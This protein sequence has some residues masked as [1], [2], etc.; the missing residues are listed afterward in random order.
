MEKE[1][2]KSKNP[3]D[4]RS[5]LTGA[6][7]AAGVAGLAASTPPVLL[8][9]NAAL[10]PEAH[11]AVDVTS[12]AKPGSDFMVDVFKTLGIEYIAANPGSSFRG[13]QE[14]S[15]NY[16][17]NKSPEWLTCC[18]EESSVAMAHGYAKIEGK[19]M[20][21]M[22]H[23]TVGLQH[24]SMAIYNA[25]CDRAP[26]YIVLGNILDVNY[27]RGNAEWVHSV[28][29]A[30]AMVRDY[31]KWDDAPVSLSHFAESAVRAYKIAMTPP[32]EPVVIVADGTL[33]EEPVTDKNLRI[34]KLTLNAP[35]QGDSDAV[36]QA[37]RMLIAADN[38]VIVAG[39]VARTPRGVELLVELA[40]LL[41]AR[42]FDQ[43]MRMNF[44]SLHPLY[45]HPGP[46]IATPNLSAYDVILGLEVQDFWGLT[47]RMTGLNKFGMEEQ[48]T[49]KPGAKIIDISAVELNHKSNYQDFGRY[50]EADLSITGDPEATLPELIE[51][52][53]RTRTIG[54]HHGFDV[55]GR[56]LADENRR[57]R[58]HDRELA[59]L[60]WD[61]SP[62]STARLSAELWAQ[63]KNDDWSLVANDRF[64]SS[65]PTRLWDFSKHY[66]YIGAQGGAGIGYQS[67]ASVGA[68]LANRKYGRLSISIQCDGDFNYAPGVLWTAAHHKI[69]LL[70]VI[71]NNRAY[72]EERMYLTMLAA[73]YDRDPG[74]SDIGTALNGPNID[75]AS[76]AKG[77]GLYAEGPISNPQELGGAF[78][79]ALERVRKGEPALVDVVTQ[80]R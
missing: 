52:I 69:P 70:M 24:A 28:Q 9:Q 50:L 3:V 37:A 73:K 22:A 14:S 40:E 39:R 54:Q 12:N 27:R 55:R 59:T 77:Y 71:H 20:M 21:I 75:Y 60:A 64:V 65:W 49:T 18:H 41:Q 29:D 58:E 26:V 51:A 68:A 72:H 17:G 32:T 61:A 38:P 4:R 45:G 1:T 67:P 35:P 46:S 23:G 31:T 8:A 7:A 11:A 53:K 2:E 6:A 48:P 15:I 62:I 34:P 44:P 36:A 57:A 76:I 63:I 47:H 10:K 74:I 78:K 80:P 19:P 66:Q 25:Y 79:R 30:A 16:G 33:Q 42:V 13:L 43:R 5:F 56:M